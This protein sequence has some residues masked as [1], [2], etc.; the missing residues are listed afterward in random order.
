[1]AMNDRSAA[2]HVQR[3]RL[4]ALLVVTGVVFASGLPR[5]NRAVSAQGQEKAPAAASK[6]PAT[7]TPATDSPAQPQI[8]L[9]YTVNNMG[10]TDTCG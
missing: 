1:M 7:E 3:K 5:T 9:A 10:Y 4:L 2:Q 6:T 8:N